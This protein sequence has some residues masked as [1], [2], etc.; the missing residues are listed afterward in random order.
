VVNFVIG[1]VGDADLNGHGS[2][3]GFSEGVVK[4]AILSALSIPGRRGFIHFRNFEGCGVHGEFREDIGS[5][6]ASF[7]AMFDNIACFHFFNGRRFFE[8]FSFL[9]DFEATGYDGL[10]S[11]KDFCLSL[12]L[13]AHVFA[14]F[15]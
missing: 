1:H 10:E 4:H 8:G 12:F 2:F 7:E 11:L 9:E 6:L 5:S 13:C 15:R 14:L 3:D